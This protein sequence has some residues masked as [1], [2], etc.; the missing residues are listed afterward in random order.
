M[1]LTSTF[2]AFKPDNFAFYLLQITSFDRGITQ[3]C[4]LFCLHFASKMRK[5]YLCA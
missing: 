2:K 5:L 1:T 3:Y 4:V